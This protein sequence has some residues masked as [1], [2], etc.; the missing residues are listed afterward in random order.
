MRILMTLLMVTFSTK[1]IAFEN[2]E[3]LVCSYNEVMEYRDKENYHV[4]D[5]PKENK[6]IIFKV[7][8][9]EL[10]VLNASPMSLFYTDERLTIVSQDDEWLSASN[11]NNFLKIRLNYENKI[12]GY[13]GQITDQL[14]AFPLRC[15]SN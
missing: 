14:V 10:N 2:N 1:L 4:Y 6:L 12:V 8:G 3:T 15:I 11:S 5:L 7:L 9:A 13:A